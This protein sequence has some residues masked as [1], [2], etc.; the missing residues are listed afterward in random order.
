LQRHRPE[1]STNIFGPALADASSNPM[2]RDRMVKSR[3]WQCQGQLPRAMASK[4]LA[5]VAAWM[6]RCCKLGFMED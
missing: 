5:K 1:T 4:I 2:R 3:S 6:R